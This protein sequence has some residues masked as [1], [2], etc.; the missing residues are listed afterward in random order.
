M[1]LDTTGGSKAMDYPEH[2]STYK[3]FLRLTQ[4]VIAFLVVL[5]TGMFVFLV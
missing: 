5:L 4:L 1:A 2:I 3:T